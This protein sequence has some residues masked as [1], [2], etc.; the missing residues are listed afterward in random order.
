[1]QTP[2]GLTSFRSARRQ[3]IIC[4][5]KQ[6]ELVWRERLAAWKQ[7]QGQQVKQAV[8]TPGELE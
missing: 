8:D 6:G 4:V 5:Y 7:M 2:E 1:M 3:P